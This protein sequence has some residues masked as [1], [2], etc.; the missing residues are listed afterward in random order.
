[1]SSCFLLKRGVQ[2]TQIVLYRTF[3]N[4]NQRPRSDSVHFV[5]LE[6]I[7]CPHILE[8]RFKTG[9]R[10]GNLPHSS[11]QFPALVAIA[12][13]WDRTVAHAL[14]VAMGAEFRAKG[15][16]V[17]EGPGMNVHRVPRGGRNSEYI[18]GEDPV[19]G[20]AMAPPLVIGIQS[21]GV[22][23]TAKHWVLN[24]QE[25]RQKKSLLP[26]SIPPSLTVLAQACLWCLGARMWRVHLP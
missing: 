18:T 7:F 21:Q 12:A 19:L 11:T 26:R 9:N 2:C 13:S 14:G 8:P 22:V 16:N 1:M 10:K 20:A 25:A 15:A 24:N 3:S 17:Q 6:P 5:P 4:E 23:A